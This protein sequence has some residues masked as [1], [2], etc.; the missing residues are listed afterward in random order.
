MSKAKL[1]RKVSEEIVLREDIKYDGEQVYYDGEAVF[2]E[3]PPINSSQY[4]CQIEENPT[5]SAIRHIEADIAST[6]QNG[7]KTK[8]QPEKLSAK[9]RV[10]AVWTEHPEWSNTKIAKAAGINRTTLYDY[11]EFKNLRATQKEDKKRIRRGSKAKD[12]TI[13]AIDE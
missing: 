12:G 3:H 8:P 13:E 4:E 10:L 1:I 9:A 5:P 7:K 11:P 6:R 2:Y